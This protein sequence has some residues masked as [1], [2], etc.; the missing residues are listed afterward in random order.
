MARHKPGVVWSVR[1]KSRSPY[2]ATSDENTVVLSMPDREHPG[3]V[4]NFPLSRR[5]ARLLAKRLN[6]CLDETRSR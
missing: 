3:W 2:V 1:P 5:D 4:L 6:Q